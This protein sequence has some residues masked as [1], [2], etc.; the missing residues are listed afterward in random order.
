M[1]E[2]DTEPDPDSKSKIW[3]L[4]AVLVLGAGPVSES[5]FLTLPVSDYR[6]S[7]TYFRL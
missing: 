1:A 7:K 4:T 3:R 2:M 6:L 5:I